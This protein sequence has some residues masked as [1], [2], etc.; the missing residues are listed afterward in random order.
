MRTSHYTEGLAKNG[1]R[2]VV[3]VAL[4]GFVLRS[5]D[6]GLLWDRVLGMNAAWLALALGAYLGMMWLGVWRWDRLLRAQHIEVAWGDLMRSLWISLFFGNFLPSNIGGDVMRVADTADAAG[7]KTLATTVIIADRVLGLVA[8]IVVASTGAFAA[9]MAGVHVPGAR[10]LWLV[11]IGGLVATIPIVAIPQLAGHLLTPV[12][13]LNNAWITERAQRM[14]DAIVKFRAAPAALAGAFAGAVAVQVSIV[15]FYLLVARGLAVPLPVFLGAVLI[16]VSLAVQMAPVSINGLGVRE[17]VFAFFFA[18]F[19]LPTEAAVALSLLS[20][21]LMMLL[22][23]V[24][25]VMFV[26]R[27]K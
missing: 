1:G 6:L 10:W 14:E 11:C 21:A 5:V 18:R 15:G 16:P 13:A 26:L 2:L 9:S 8:L 12:R 17:A 25:G 7:S 20:A 23:L 19:G 22:S 4:L 3:S 27:R 24:G